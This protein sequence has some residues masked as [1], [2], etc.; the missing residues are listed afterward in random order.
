MAFS[1]EER[2]LLL[3]APRIGP[4]VIDRLQAVGLDSLEALRRVGV[5]A[6]VERVCQ[7]LGSTAWANRRDAI[8][9]VLE[10]QAPATE[11]C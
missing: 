8:Q 3:R 7:H 4:A 1:D 2:A 5:D 6:A 11:R 9:A 10:R